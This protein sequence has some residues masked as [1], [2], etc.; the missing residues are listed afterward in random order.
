MVEIQYRTEVQ[1]AWATAVEVAD[2]L[3]GRRIKFDREGDRF[4]QLCS[5]ALARKFENMNSCLPGLSDDDVLTEL[6]Q[7]E[8]VHGTLDFLGGLR[9]EDIDFSK[10]S[11]LVLILDEEMS[12]AT[13]NDPISA[14]NFRSEVEKDRPSANVVYVSAENPTAIKKTFQNYFRNTRDFVE[15]VRRAIDEGLGG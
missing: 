3:Q 7:H 11:Y 12:V 1:H 14:L 6:N 5:E 8:A 15:L 4:F 9:E 10:S 13:F 2:T